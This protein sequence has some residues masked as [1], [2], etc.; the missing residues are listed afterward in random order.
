VKISRSAF[1]AVKAHVVRGFPEEICGMLLAAKG[2]RD[3]T[4]IHEAHNITKENR[5]TTYEIAH[6]EHRQ[7]EDECDAAGLEIVGYYHSHPDHGSYASIRDSER[8]WPDSFYL[9]VSCMAGEV[10]E[11]KVFT[12]LTWD[13]QKMVEQPMQVVAE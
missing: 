13:A 12:K 6:T 9:I 1:D 8:A 10:A 3:V 11:S 4:R 5:Q 7:I 2:S